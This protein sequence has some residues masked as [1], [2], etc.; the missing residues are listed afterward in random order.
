MK[1]NVMCCQRASVVS[2][3]TPVTEFHTAGE[4]KRISEFPSLSASLR[5]TPK[6]LTSGQGNASDQSEPFKCFW[7]EAC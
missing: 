2:E 7:W 1:V 4:R 3:G 6:L 5:L